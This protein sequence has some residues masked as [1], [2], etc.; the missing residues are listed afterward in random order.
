MY[1]LAYLPERVALAMFAFALLCCQA[2]SVEE[3]CEWAIAIREAIA[4][5]EGKQLAFEEEEQQAGQR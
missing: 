4:V 3:C 1:P 2:A 5:A